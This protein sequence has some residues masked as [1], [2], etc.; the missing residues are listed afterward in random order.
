[1]RKS[2]SNKRNSTKRSSRKSSQKTLKRSSKKSSSKRSSSKRSPVKSL[3]ELKN[4]VRSLAKRSKKSSKYIQPKQHNHLITGHIILK[5][6]DNERKSFRDFNEVS[7]KKI[8]RIVKDH[9]ESTSEEYRT[10][11]KYQVTAQGKIFLSFSDK[12]QVLNAKKN[13]RSKKKLEAIIRDEI[14]MFVELL[15]E[16]DD[17]GN[18]PVQGYLVSIGKI[19]LDDKIFKLQLY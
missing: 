8:L 15:L 4:L 9:F 16:V 13:D 10:N 3:R 12:Q 19:K 2:S 11:I 7:K 14:K 17:D 18:Y 6:D 5:N 1:M